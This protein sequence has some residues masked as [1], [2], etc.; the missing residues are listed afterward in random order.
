ME[1]LV[2]VAIIGLLAGRGNAGAQYNLGACYYKGE[3]VTK[4][5]K[6]AVKWFTKSAEQGNVYAQRDL[7]VAYY[8][9]EGVTQDYKEAVKWFT[10]S[11]EQ[12]NAEAK[13]AL[14]RMKSK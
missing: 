8:K 6:E 3:G 14:E 10:K 5:E 9:G 7:G 2:C 1:L 11:A 13:E 4:D 12:G